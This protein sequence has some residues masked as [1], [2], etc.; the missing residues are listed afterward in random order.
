[1][2]KIRVVGGI[3][4]DG[5]YNLSAIHDT[6]GASANVVNTTMQV[7]RSVDLKRSSFI[8]DEGKWDE[9]EWG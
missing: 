8:W 5:K 1:M 2:K 3:D 6:Q 7:L 4:K 9:E